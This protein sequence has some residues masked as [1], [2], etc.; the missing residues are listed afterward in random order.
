ME[1]GLKLVESKNYGDQ[2]WEENYKNG[3]FNKYP[4]DE[5]VSFTFRNFKQKVNVLDL[6]CGGGNN[7]KFLLEQGHKVYAVDGS[8]TSLDLTKV[9]CENHSNLICL[10]NGFKNLEIK[11]NIIEYIIDRQSLGHNSREDIEKIIEE[12]YRVL[13]NDGKMISF[14]FS[15]GHKS[16][17]NDKFIG[18]N[19]YYKFETGPFSKS[20][21]VYFTN[22]EE[23][24]D[25]FKKFQIID[26]KKINMKSLKGS[27][28]IE[29]FIVELKKG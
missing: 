15:D 20:G 28:D 16:L 21:Y 5:V 26:I 6:G 2:C 9:L 4:Y 19:K 12:L 22:Q 14:L 18:K 29:Y 7:T 17:I 1:K 27:F 10:H 25:L 13:K 24:E 23:I 8:K 3:R 11:D